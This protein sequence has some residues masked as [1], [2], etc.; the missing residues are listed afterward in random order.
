VK[1]WDTSA[2]VPLLLEEERTPEMLELYGR[3]PG[4][5]VWWGTEVECVSAVSRLEREGRL[6]A[7]QSARILGSLQKMLAS[8]NEVQA[9]DEVREAAKR[10]LRVHDLRAA[11]AFQLAAAHVVSE[12]RPGSLDFV[13][14]DRRLAEAALRE[15]FVVHGYG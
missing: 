13:T 9:V 3:D 10:F 15:G 7:R 12:G 1:F 4:V 11:D 14:L 2:L 5:F 6:D 8:W